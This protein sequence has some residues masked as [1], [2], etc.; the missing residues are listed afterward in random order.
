MPSAGPAP[1]SRG[2]DAQPLA[3]T[4]RAPGSP[5][6]PTAV[7]PQRWAL[8]AAMLAWGAGLAAP[9]AGEPRAIVSPA[10][11]QPGGVIVVHVEGVDP[12]ASLEGTVAGRSLAFFPTAAGMTA[13]VGIDLEAPAGSD[14]WTVSVGSHGGPNTIARGLLTIGPREF[15]VERLTLPR[16]LVELDPETA[17]R[18]EMESRRL[19][20]L[21]ATA[22]PERWWRGPFVAPVDSARRTGGF[23]ARRVI[24]GLLRA[25]HAGLDYSA[26]RGTPVVAA[27]A[28][29]VVLTGEFFFPGR[30]VVLDH[31]LGLYTAY[32]HLD[33]IMV[34]EQEVVPRR[35][36]L[37]TVGA[38][39]RAT[40][41][42]LHFAV[43][44]GSARIDPARLLGVSL[45][46]DE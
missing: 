21:Y 6:L 39:G 7:A 17:R 34:A 19:R 38:T 45:P 44:L 20:A 13:L 41:P 32:F 5:G 43:T 23:G 22:T 35:A 30:L 8:L 28:G 10:V 14:A 37:G 31:G 18:A 29:R 15:P 2:G 9:A 33:R 40:G 46:G 1:G 42:H 27:N 36:L 26:E 25:P 12:G 4:G 11:V 24:N 16:G 3:P